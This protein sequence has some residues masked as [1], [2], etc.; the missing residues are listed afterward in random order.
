[1]SILNDA[2]RSQ[3]L[4]ATKSAAIAFLEDIQYLR[5]LIATE[6][7]SAAEIRHLSNLLRRLLINGELREVAAPRIGRI[8]ILVKQLKPFWT[9]GD[10]TFFASL[11]ANVF[12]IEFDCMRLGA[13]KP[14]H[15]DPLSSYNPDER[16]EVNVDG[17]CSQKVLCLQGDW[18]T[19]GQ[20]I[21]YVANVAS[22][23]HTKSP[24]EPFEFK[25][26]KMRQAAK[27]SISHGVVNFGIDRSILIVANDPPLQLSKN[28]IDVVLL[29][30]LAAATQLLRSTDIL[31][32]E[33]L[34]KC[35]FAA[36][37]IS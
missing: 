24:R 8:H 15:V 34:I 12:G 20:V 4:A 21:K 3:L 17:F 27:C 32:L 23:V 5:S 36:A 10:Y 25:L 35:E 13:S 33:E 9:D 2:Q 26:M 18:I 7:A 6:N 14:A 22:G 1:M 19:R 11:G 37:S 16:I 31:R 29:E 28:S 30:L